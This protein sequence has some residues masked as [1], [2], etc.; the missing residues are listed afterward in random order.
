MNEQRDGIYLRI[1]GDNYR[2]IFVMGD[3]HGCYSSLLEVLDKAKFDEEYDLLISVG[4]LIDRGHDN[5]DCLSLFNKPWFR[6]VKGN[7]EEM[8]IES[9]LYGKNEERW[10]RNGGHWYYFL[11]KEQEEE[12]LNLI[13]RAELLPLVIEVDTAEKRTVIAHADYPSRQYAFGK[14]IDEELTVWSR[15]RYYAVLEGRSDTIV[16]ADN[17]YFGHTPVKQTVDSGNVHYIDTGC[18]FGGHLTLVK[19][20]G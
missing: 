8:A 7:H 6:A 9:L 18:V 1:N 16:G 11:N 20:K 19:I 14:E 12:A 10:Y 3:I 15:D 5:I 2:R 17:F 4:D 13:V